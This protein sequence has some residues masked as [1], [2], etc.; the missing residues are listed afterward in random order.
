MQ[1][2]MK[3]LF[4]P[5]VTLMNRLSYPRKMG[6]V[7][8]VFSLTL[9]AFLYL[10]ISE[11]N[12]K[13]SFSKKEIL[14]SRYNMTMNMFLKDLQQHR[15]LANVFLMGDESFRYSLKEKQSR[16]KTDI[17]MVE[18]MEIKYG[19]ILQTTEKWN[20][21]KKQWQVILDVMT[22]LK[23][24]DI[25]QAHTALAAETLDIMTHVADVSSMLLDSD[26]DIYY[27][28]DTMINSLPQAAEYAGQIRGRGAG[29]VVMGRLNSQE[30]AH[31]L[32]LSGLF[33]STLNR[34]SKNLQK[35]YRENPL[36]KEKLDV[37]LQDA[38]SEGHYSLDMLDNRVLFADSINIKPSEYFDA[39]T[40]TINKLFALNSLIAVS[41]DD[42]LDERI[43]HSR[44]QRLFIITGA[45]L[46]LLIIAYL[47]AGHY[48]SVMN[49]LSGLVKASRRIGRGEFNGHLPVETM[50]EMAEVTKSFDEMS[51]SIEEFTGQLKSIN[52][53]L[54]NEIRERK[55]A[56][57]VLRESK[58]SLSTLLSNLPGM[59]YRCLNDHDWTMKFVSEG[60]YD[61]TG[62]KYTDLVDNRE[63]AYAALIVPQDQ[64]A[65]WNDVQAALNLKKPFRLVY[66]IR[67][68]SG[69]D[70]WLYC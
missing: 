42:L 38:L 18:N 4:K 19:K 8:I 23:A 69:R 34:S 36:L 27:L 33:K 11:I 28:T 70:K 59:A 14:G 1:S 50:D 48:F 35:V 55:H 17:E 44:M 15:G 66:R 2:P 67:H 25:F 61:L 57:E 29:A 30:K 22:E 60:A 32:V 53:A 68:K 46:T 63:I 12:L 20:D 41:L 16:I 47:S 26:I 37:N 10:L 9:A 21:I 49:A 45:L 52:E 43:E 65:V 51:K 40:S 62:Y 7:A 13:I 5:A 3:Q 31:L 6:V 24:E 56:G 54:E 64:D 39:F 58:R